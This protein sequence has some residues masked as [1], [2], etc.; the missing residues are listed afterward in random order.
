MKNLISRILVAVD[1]SVESMAAATHAI[2]IARIYDAELFTLTIINTQ[3]WFH[4][5]TLYGWADDQTME[6]VY[7]KDRNESQRWADQIIDN[8]KV[9]GIKVS[10]KILM[11]PTT[12]SSTPAAIVNYAEQN[13]IDI[14]VMGTRGR[15]GFKKMLLGSTALGVLTYAHCP[16]MIVK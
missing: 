3:P 12:S 4:S 15:S 1:G 11:V 6:K 7:A 9:N 8:A 14:I 16:V 5:S 13:N 10:T 2:T